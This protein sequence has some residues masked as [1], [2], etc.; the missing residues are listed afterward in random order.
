MFIKD[1]LCARHF[2][3]A[4]QNHLILTQSLPSKA[5]AHSTCEETEEQ[6][7]YLVS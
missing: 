4:L 7:A 1:A 5:H 2:A 6:S 3:G